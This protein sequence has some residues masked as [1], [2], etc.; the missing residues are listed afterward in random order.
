MLYARGPFL[1][2]MFYRCHCPLCPFISVVLT[3]P[4]RTLTAM[5]RSL[6]QL[7]VRS[8]GLIGLP[9]AIGNLTALKE[10]HLSDNAIRTLPSTFG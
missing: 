8:C 9:S 5:G 6:Q 7:S 2:Y 3:V 10:L 1:W 4:I